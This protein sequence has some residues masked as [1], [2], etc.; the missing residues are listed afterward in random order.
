[1]PETTTTNSDAADLSGPAIVTTKKPRTQDPLRAAASVL[2]DARKQRARLG[3]RINRLSADLAK[4][5]G[6][7]PEADAAVDRALAALNSLTTPPPK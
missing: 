2:A 5:E 4:A 7:V 3:L 6:E 1:M